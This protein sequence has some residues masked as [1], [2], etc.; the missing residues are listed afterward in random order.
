M[1]R[2]PHQSNSNDCEAQ[3][4]GGC[5]D[6][7]FGLQKY[8]DKHQKGENRINIMFI[9]ILLTEIT[10]TKNANSVK[11]KFGIYI[12]ETLRHCFNKTLD[13]TAQETIQSHVLC[14]RQQSM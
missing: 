3:K 13:S 5:D 12:K 8:H 7:Q 14:T 1:E 9:L 10:V 11:E 4:H 2:Q 6:I